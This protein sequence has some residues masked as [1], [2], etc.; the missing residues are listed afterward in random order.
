MRNFQRT[1]SKMASFRQFE[2]ESKITWTILTGK[3]VA[4]SKK[5]TD[6][7]I[8][9]HLGLMHESR[10]VF[11]GAFLTLPLITSRMLFLRTHTQNVELEL[12]TKPPLSICHQAL[13]HGPS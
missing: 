3:N 5:V 1:I 8:R 10:E 7:Q 12:I 2:L 11:F 13:S 6:K 4:R 9:K